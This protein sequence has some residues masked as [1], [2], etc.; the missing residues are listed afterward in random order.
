MVARSAT[1]A[2]PQDLDALRTHGFSDEDIL[3]AVNIIGF[4]AYYTRLAD[5]LGVEPEPHWAQ[6]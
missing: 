5:A 2:T 6:P 3:D 4:F 1:K